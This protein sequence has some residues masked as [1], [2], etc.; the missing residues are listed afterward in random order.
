MH[1][2]TPHQVIGFIATRLL[3]CDRPYGH[4]G[5]WTPVWTDCGDLATA[6]LGRE[7]GKGCEQR[8]DGE[9]K[10]RDERMEQMYAAAKESFRRLELKTQGVEEE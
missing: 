8:S 3:S 6:G 7:A 5:S 10:K 2:N 9:G 1:P 4:P